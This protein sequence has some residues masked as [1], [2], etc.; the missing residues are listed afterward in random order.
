MR[1]DAFFGP[2]LTRRERKKAVCSRR[3]GETP[4]GKSNSGRKNTYSKKDCEIV[5]PINIFWHPFSIPCNKVLLTVSRKLQTQRHHQNVSYFSNIK[6]SSTRIPSFLKTV[7]FFFFVVAFLPHV[8]S[9]RPFWAPEPRFLKT[10]LRMDIFLKHRG[11]FFR[12]DGLKGQFSK[13]KMLYLYMI[14]HTLC[15]GWFSLAT[16]S[17]SESES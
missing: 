16:E 11:L 5:E 4:S 8:N 2:C 7:N 6:A 17:E 12:V 1:A 15:K 3:L 9:L 14:Q 13:T 10:G